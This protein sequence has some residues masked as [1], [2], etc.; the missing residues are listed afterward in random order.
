MATRTIEA[1]KH[2]CAKVFS[3][4]LPKTKS[5]FPY[6]QIFGG[7]TERERERERERGGEG[8]GGGTERGG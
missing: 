2:T 1:N 8:W 6:Y 7:E 3:S 5:E 4:C